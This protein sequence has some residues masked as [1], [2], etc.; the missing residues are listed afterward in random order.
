MVYLELIGGK[1]TKLN[2]NKVDELSIKED[3]EIFD[4][5]NYYSKK[6]ILPI[7]RVN[8]NLFDNE[9]HLEC[10]KEIPQSIW[11]KLKD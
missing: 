9:L 3:N 8:I 4:L 10:L 5:T 1:Q 2:F 11:E 6:E 7:K